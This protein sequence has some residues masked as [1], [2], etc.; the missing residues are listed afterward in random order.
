MRQPSRTTT[1]RLGAGVLVVVLGALTGLVVA[2]ERGA[3]TSSS[4]IA[5][6]AGRVVRTGATT[7]AAVVPGGAAATGAS[8]AA[9]PDVTGSNTML[10][11]VGAFLLLCAAG[12]W[13]LLRTGHQERTH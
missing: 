2:L 4:P 6:A 13:A 10:V 3:T 8:A 5:I 12:A 11:M 9:L 1:H 7:E